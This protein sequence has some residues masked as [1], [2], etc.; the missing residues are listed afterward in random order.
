MIPRPLLAVFVLILLFT[1]ACGG[2]GDSDDNTTD[3]AAGSTPAAQTESNEESDSEELELDEDYLQGE[4]CS[5]HEGDQE[6]TTYIFDGNSFEYGRGDSLGSGGNIPTFLIGM[7]V[8]SVEQ[9]Q[10]VFTEF[11][12]EVTFTRGSCS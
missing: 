9:D 10:F 12:R 11:G 6:G 7:R 8:V 1:A 2:D 3:N 5:R 4:W